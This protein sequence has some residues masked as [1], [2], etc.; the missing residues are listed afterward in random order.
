MLTIVYHQMSLP[1]SCEGPCDLRALLCSHSEGP[2]AALP[3]N[4][5]HSLCLTPC[6]LKPAETAAGHVFKCC[7]LAPRG[8]LFALFTLPNCHLA[9][10]D[11]YSTFIQSCAK[12]IDFIERDLFLLF[13]LPLVSSPLRG[14]S[15]CVCVCVFPSRSRHLHVRRTSPLRHSSS[16]KLFWSILTCRPAVLLR[17][18]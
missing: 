8:S 5:Q 16:L 14:A 10:C 7:K 6:E 15:L 12:L 9:A 3:P 17:L 11:I 13:S 4:I 2:G 1:L 18:R